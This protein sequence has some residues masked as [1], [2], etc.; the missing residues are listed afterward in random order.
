MGKVEKVIVLSVLFLIALI[1]AVS[2]TVDDPLDKS[3]VVEAGSTPHNPATAPAAQPTPSA[4][5][6]DNQAVPALAANV[7]AAG[8][9]AAPGLLSMPIQTDGNATAPGANVPAGDNSIVPPAAAIGLPAG[10]LLKRNDGLKD[11]IL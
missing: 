4:N 7:P 6:G 8:G 1:L 2:L 9:N 10:A 11:S 5:A 3:R